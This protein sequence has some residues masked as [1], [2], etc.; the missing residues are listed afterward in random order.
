MIDG[1]ARDGE[2]ENGDEEEERCWKY[3]DRA[4]WQVGSDANVRVGD[5][6]TVW[7]IC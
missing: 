2:H 7:M 5:F 3:L 4:A 1:E 6:D